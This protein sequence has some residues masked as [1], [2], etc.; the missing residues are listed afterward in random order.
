MQ[1]RVPGFTLIELMIVVGIVGILTAIVYP[2]YTNS[3]REGRRAEAITNL[4]GVQFAQERFR[5][6][7]PNYSGTLGAGAG[8]LVLPAV[9][10][11]NGTPYYDIVIA[12]GANATAFIA[13]ATARATGNQNQDTDNGVACN[14][15]TV[16][17]AGP[18]YN[19]AGQIACWG[20][21]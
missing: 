3:V 8:G 19:P 16:N 9:S 14:V 13:T 6:N 2:F 1:Q 15:L 21:N 12:A 20:R 17:Q 18:V 5:A 11:A 7:N 4:L 10:P